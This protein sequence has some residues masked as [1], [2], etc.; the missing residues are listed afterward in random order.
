MLRVR[1]NLLPDEASTRHSR[2]REYFCD[3]DA[4]ASLVNGEWQLE[5]AWPGGVERH[6]DS[7]IEQELIA[8]G[9][10]DLSKMATAR[11][12]S[13][14]VLTALYDTWTLLSWSKWIARAHPSPE[15]R[16]T[17]LHI[18]DHRDLGAPRLAVAAS[19][20][21]DLITGCHF[22]V[23]NPASVLAACESG[24]VGM[25]S[26][27]TPLLLAFPK[28]DVRQLA[29]P[30]KI[31]H[32]VDSAFSASTVIDDL[33]R[34]GA[35]RPAIRLHPIESGVAAGRYRATNNLEDWLRDIEVGPV[36]LH[37]DM[38]YFNNRYDGDGDWPHH[39]ARHDPPL[40]AVLARID[41]IT[42][43]MRT[44]GILS[45]IEDAAV[46]FSPGFFPAEMWQP[47]EARL[48]AGLEELY[49]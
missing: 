8:W 22:D 37:V 18:D 10:I 45:R 5:L 25:G 13:G 12:R 17:I 28:C 42:S 49:A 14:R 46:A 15:Q 1:S 9:G 32:T 2:L 36:L 48:R 11:R 24:A 40:D 20:L 4:T 30:P 7:R 34:P 3:K 43:T 35:F 33:L 29:Q 16:I 31:I 6:I 27:L 44:N 21:E 39:F 47:A 26:F 19:G 38:D 23:R 41:E